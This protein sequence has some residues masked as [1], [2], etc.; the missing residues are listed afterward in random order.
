MTTWAAAP[1]YGDTQGQQA[2]P[3]IQL[4]SG[5]GLMNGTGS[6]DQGIEVFSPGNE[7]SRAQL[8]CV[9]QR[10]FQLD[11]GKMKFIKAPQA[12][13]YYQDVN[14][15]AWYASGLVMCAINKVFDSGS[16][17]YPDRSV[18]RIELARGIMR[19]FNA[20][21]INV[22]M[23]MMMPVYEDTDSLSQ[24]DMNA[25]VFVNNTGI[26]K[27]DGQYFRPDKLVNRA[28]LS[29]VLSGC[30]SLMALD[31]GSNGMDYQIAVGQTF[32]ISLNSNPTTGYCWNIWDDKSFEEQNV[33]ENTGSVYRSQSDKSQ[34]LVGRGGR[35]YWQ[36]KAL[37]TGTIELKLGYARPWESVQPAQVFT[38]KVNVI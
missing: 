1:E 18:S 19:S 10:T 3:D 25:M 23:I 28:E 22:P 31:E 26:M 37:H 12:S 35:E 9:L 4:V 27:G 36:F 11:Y 16:E 34:G 14:N 32:I 24:E 20:K 30:I 15:D 17:F 6:N 2:E 8:A 5:L 21:G 13:D 33:L 7:V 38:L 29:E